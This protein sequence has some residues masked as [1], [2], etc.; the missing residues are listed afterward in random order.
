MKRKKNHC[1]FSAGGNSLFK[2]DLLFGGATTFK[3]SDQHG[4]KSDQHCFLPWREAQNLKRDK[5]GSDEQR[6]GKRSI[7]FFL[8]CCQSR[9]VHICFPAISRC[10]SYTPTCL[11]SSGD[12]ALSKIVSFKAIFRGSGII[13]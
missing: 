3:N 8:I 1:Y 5:I 2:L 9:C 13:K 10:Y 6:S 11:T 7:L 4:V 12:K